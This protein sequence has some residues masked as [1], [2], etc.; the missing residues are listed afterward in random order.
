MSRQGDGELWCSNRYQIPSGFGLVKNSHDTHVTSLNH[1]VVNI[2][3]SYQKI[4]TIPM[5]V[6]VQVP[7]SVST[8]QQQT[9]RIFNIPAGANA[10]TAA[11][12]V[13]SNSAVST[14]ASVNSSEGLGNIADLIDVKKGTIHPAV[15][16]PGVENRIAMMEKYKSLK[17]EDLQR[18]DGNYEKYC[19][20]LMFFKKNVQS[21]VKIAHIPRH[22]ESFP[23]LREFWTRMDPFFCIH[24]FES[25]GIDL[26]YC[27]DAYM[28]LCKKANDLKC[29]NGRFLF[30][31]HHDMIGVADGNGVHMNYKVNGDNTNIVLFETPMEALA[32]YPGCFSKYLD[33]N[34]TMFLVAVD[35][36]NPSPSKLYTSKSYAGS[37]GGKQ[38]CIYDK[39]LV[40]PMVNFT[41]KFSVYFEGLLKNMWM[42]P[43]EEVKIKFHLW[44]K[45]NRDQCVVNGVWMWKSF[46]DKMKTVL[47]LAPSAT[48]EE[49]I[50]F[51][52]SND[53]IIRLM[54]KFTNLY[55]ITRFFRI[56]NA[57]TDYSHIVSGINAI[58]VNPD[59]LVEEVQKVWAKNEELLNKVKVVVHDVPNDTVIGIDAQ[60]IT[61][62]KRKIED[63]VATDD[64]TKN[65]KLIDTT[66]ASS[67]VVATGSSPASGSKPLPVSVVSSPPATTA[68]S[69]FAAV[70]GSPPATKANSSSAAGA[71]S[72]PAAGA[73]SSAAVTVKS[74][75]TAGA[76]SS[77]AAG[78]KSS[79]AVTV[80]SPP[81]AG[82]KSSPAQGNSTGSPSVAQ[83]ESPAAPKP[84]PSPVSK[85]DFS[86]PP[87]KRRNW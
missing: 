27:R 22:Y 46:I 21:I 53:V 1:F 17:T 72:S 56:L 8:Q 71:K 87:K 6:T 45:L 41:C 34:I 13:A 42:K 9:T 82:A 29:E 33:I 3:H 64:V 10:A 83:T 30:L 11:S 35:F 70:V 61:G 12:V 25:N 78:A 14:V 81:T 54:W 50:R 39:D 68:N 52:V 62:Q 23:I 24:H 51:K 28:S 37:S 55:G 86:V 77:P 63:S 84:K 65:E 76:K 16:F 19:E 59:S 5:D 49:V 26:L 85:V 18:L 66:V 31:A 47:Q 69:S 20:A 58:I 48:F 67:T 57:T 15:R 40:V 38:Y 75:P 80:K 2:S 36:E 4:S 44:C 73:K 7:A 60:N 79:T 74:P 43:M 32:Q